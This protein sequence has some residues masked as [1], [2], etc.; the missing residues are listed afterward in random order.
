MTGEI[1]KIMFFLSSSVDKPIAKL[2]L[3]LS[4]LCRFL[5]YHFHIVRC[6]FLVNACTVFSHE[7]C[8]DNDD[9]NLNLPLGLKM[10]SLNTSINRLS[11]SLKSV[12]S[13][14]MKDGQ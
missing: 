11:S 4:G 5:L 13:H 12:N 9:G 1:A 10:F 8:A 6:H 7:Q 14:C 2:Y 3:L